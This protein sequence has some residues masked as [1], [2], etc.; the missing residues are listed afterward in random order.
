MRTNFQVILWWE[1]NEHEAPTLMYNT[2]LRLD[3]A[4]MSALSCTTGVVQCIRFRRGWLFLW[5]T[6]FWL[7][8]NS[9]DDW[10]NWQSPVPER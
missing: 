9:G 1:V 4:A 2:C 7:H 10:A 5:P 6:M 8:G 3:M